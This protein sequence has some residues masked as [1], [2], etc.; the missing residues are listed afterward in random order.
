MSVQKYN[1][2]IEAHAYQIFDDVVAIIDCKK[3][4]SLTNSIEY[5]IKIISA[6]NGFR[7]Q[8]KKWIYRDSIDIWDGYDPVRNNFITLSTNSFPEAL[9]MIRGEK[10]IKLPENHYR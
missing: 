6:Q 1:A 4:M 9:A 2:P 7:P 8:D 10:F 3:G 5:W